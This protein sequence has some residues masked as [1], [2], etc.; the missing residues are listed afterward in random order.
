MTDSRARQ[1]FSIGVLFAG[2]ALFSAGCAGKGGTTVA[3]NQELVIT[4]E[5]VSQTVPIDRASTFT[6]AATGT[7]PLSF[8]WSKN[9]VEIAGANGASY[10]TPTIALADSGSTFRVSVS[11]ASSSAI[12]STATLTVGPRAPGL[13]DLRYL[14]WQQVTVPW[15]NGGDAVF[16]GFQNES[17]T[18]ALGTPLEIGSALVRSQDCTWEAGV[19]FV[20]TTMNSLGL[21]MFYQWDDTANTPYASYLDSI[22]APNIVITSMDL[23]PAC[24]AIG[25]SWVQT[26]QA[27][28]FDYRLET[29]PLTQI[30]DTLTADGAEGRV[31]TAVTFDDSS[32]NAVLISYGWSGDTATVYE[33][34]SI[35]A[36]PTDVANQ[37]TILAGEG[38]F[39][40]AFGGNDTDGYML[41]G[42]RVQGDTLSRPTAGYAGASPTS[43]TV[44]FTTVVWFAEPNGGGAQLGEQ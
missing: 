11:D 16:V 5:P 34:K 13:G 23:E 29:V 32:R 33:A 31:V 25:V 4:T 40:S 43:E 30:Q 9:G 38:Y 14:L 6:V 44:P 2:A 37:A 1:H 22:A 27:G 7:L 21:T 17:I 35:V 26:A 15:S 39:I 18:D 19:L 41:I 24:N 12:S 3:P 8:Q 20:P 42:M 28:Q 36:M 10:T